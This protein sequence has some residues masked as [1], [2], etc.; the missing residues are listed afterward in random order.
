MG[1]V[2]SVEGLFRLFMGRAYGY[3]LRI[4]VCDF[5]FPTTGSH[6]M[7]G[8]ILYA[9]PSDVSQGGID[10]EKSFLSGNTDLPGLINEEFPGPMSFYCEKVIS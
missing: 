1:L 6:S 10:R 5:A 4:S 3:N 9:F 2:N 7:S 8:R